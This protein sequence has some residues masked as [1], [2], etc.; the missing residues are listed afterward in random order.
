MA[1]SITQTDMAVGKKI[2][3]LVGISAAKQM[4]SARCGK[5]CRFG[6]LATV[7]VS[8]GYGEIAEG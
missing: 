8:N 1:K 7:K 5:D 3:Y 2:W 6:K 4:P